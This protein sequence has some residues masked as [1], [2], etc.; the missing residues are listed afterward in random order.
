[1]WLPVPQAVSK[2]KSVNLT[3]HQSRLF[4][5]DC[6]LIYG[7]SIDRRVT[8]KG[9]SNVATLIGRPVILKFVMREADLYSLIFE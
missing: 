5:N 6:D 1:M 3:V 8:W 4:R 9:S 2:W 7:D